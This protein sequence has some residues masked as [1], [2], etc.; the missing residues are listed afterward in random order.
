MSRSP[1]LAQI[2]T[3]L[4]LSVFI[5]LAALVGTAPASYFLHSRALLYWFAGEAIIVGGAYLYSNRSGAPIS[6]PASTLEF[7]LRGLAAVSFWGFLGI[8]TISTYQFLFLII[9]LI[10]FLIHWA[11]FGLTI[12]A[13]TISFYVTFVLAVGLGLGIVAAISEA[14][15]S[16]IYSANESSRSAIYSL[17]LGGQARTWLYAFLNLAAIAVMVV[18]LRL[19]GGVKGFWFHFLV[20][21]IPYAAS[22]WLLSL[23]ER[24]R[25]DSETVE[26]VGRLV[27]SLDFDVVYAPRAEDPSLQTLLSGVDIIATRGDQAVII[28][29]KT[30]SSSTD[31]V[32]WT[33]GSGL[34]L[35]A[36]ALQLPTIAE[37]L[38]TVHLAGKHVEPLLVI[39]GRQQDPSLTQ[40]SAEENLSVVPIDMATINRVLNLT[41]DGEIKALAQQYFAG[42]A[43]TVLETVAKP[44]EQATEKQG[45][46]V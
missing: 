11:G 33:A 36:K 14:V 19:F 5:A 1:Q 44:E 41:D 8:L 4:L 31:A 15:T 32:D 42:L 22:G 3:L 30:G 26:A 2:G 7:L 38:E 27:S 40:Y 12:N 9:R 24:V 6:Q 35:K 29:V 28:Q 13:A 21:C 17:A 16:R 34:R 20:Q 46:W 25:G 10:A 23:G 45:Q 39:C 18:L 43:G 37:K